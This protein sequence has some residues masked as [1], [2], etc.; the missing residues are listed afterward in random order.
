MDDPAAGLD[1]R[2]TN[3]DDLPRRHRRLPPLNA[4]RA[5]EAAAR[6]GSFT[7]AAAELLV[8]QTAVSHQVKILEE[9]VGA[10]LFRRL[11]NSLELTERGAGYLPVLREAFERIAEA[12]DELRGSAAPQALSISTLPNFALRWLIPRLPR[13]RALHPD[14]ALRLSTADRTTDFMNGQMDVAVRLGNSW[15]G[16]RQALLFPG[17]IFPVCSPDMLRGRLPT[18]PSDL[19][20]WP[21]L[22]VS[23]SAED[24]PAWLAA[25][26][27]EG[28]D[29]AAGMRFD[30]FAL[31]SEAALQGMGFAM[32]RLPFVNEDLQAGRLIAP[33]EFRLDQEKAY[34]L[35]WPQGHVA[36]PVTRFREWILAEAALSRGEARC[37]ATPPNGSWAPREQ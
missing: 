14:I 16:L 10:R 7:R 1:G 36:R 3:R 27:A 6:H 9:F 12:T 30:S 17:E 4:L 8:T 28:V 31:A 35:L 11:H 33:F 37:A 32:A 29:G 19:A 34:Y 25:A 21:L 23:T 26:G 24:W 20:A 18:S 13:F 2:G 15:P 5:F 22:H